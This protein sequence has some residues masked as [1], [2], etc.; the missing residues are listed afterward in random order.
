MDGG[1]F[2][3]A[4]PHVKLYIKIEN[5]FVAIEGDKMIGVYNDFDVMTVPTF[6]YTLV[7]FHEIDDRSGLHVYKPYPPL[8]H[9]K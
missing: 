9:S 7:Y 5:P 6:G 2:Q 4:S 8:A 3:T 1:F